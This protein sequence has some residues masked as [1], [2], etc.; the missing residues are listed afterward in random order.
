MMLKLLSNKGELT[1]KMNQ[2]I[3]NKDFDSFESKGFKVGSV[4]ELFPEFS[5]TRI[6]MMPFYIYD[7]ASIPESLEHYKPVIIAMLSMQPDFVKSFEGNTAYL[8]ID[9]LFVKAGAIQRNA[10]LHVDGMYN[11]TLAG[12]WGGNGGSWGSCTN[13]MLLASNTDDLC[14]YWTGHVDGV[15]I[16]D[17]DCE[18]LK[19][20]LQ[21]MTEHS[22]KNGDVVWADG[23]LIHESLPTRKDINRQFIRI[24]LPNNAPWFVGYTE[25]PLGILPCG[26]IINTRR[27]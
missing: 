25:N 14:K 24:S 16:N 26:E 1:M 12:A 11:N 2:V 7:I 18:H 17:G 3:T 13:G 23:L 27:I 10:G 5:E 19:D 22:M 15:P 6:M 9:E 8:T 20:Q 21:K 4:K